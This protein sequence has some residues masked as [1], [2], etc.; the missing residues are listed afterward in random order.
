MQEEIK[1]V[2]LIYADA[3]ATIDDPG[4]QK[5]L[6]LFPDSS[7]DKYLLKEYMML[8]FFL[9]MLRLASIDDASENKNL[10]SSITDRTFDEVIRIISAEH[11]RE[12][13]P[14]EISVRIDAYTKKRSE[15]PNWLT[16]EFLN[17]IDKKIIDIDKYHKELDTIVGEAFK[18]I[19]PIVENPAKSPLYQGFMDSIP[20]AKNTSNR[21]GCLLNLILVIM[22]VLILNIIV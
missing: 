20:K 9:V 16:D 15:D 10:I 2:S 5:I 1:I 6:K 7:Q 8:K 21:S 4:A 12:C 19:I 11:Y 22:I 18:F 14:Q 3:I 13:T 17:G